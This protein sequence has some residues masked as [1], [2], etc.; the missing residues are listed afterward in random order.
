MMDASGRFR[1]F[2]AGYLSN[3]SSRYPRR[4]VRIKEIVRKKENP[5][6]TWTMLN[7]SGF[8]AFDYII[9]I[10]GLQLVMHY[11]KE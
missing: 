10:M 6:I 8:Y 9:I 2:E 3:I 7:G 1:R 4:R 11:R 5:L